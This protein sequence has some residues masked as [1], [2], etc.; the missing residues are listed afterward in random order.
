[1]AER[2][3]SERMVLI[4][5]TPGMLA[6]DLESTHA[7]AAATGTTL[8]PDWPPPFHTDE[9]VRR[10]QGT[11]ADPAGDGWWLHYFAAR[12]GDG[13]GLRL[14]GEG[15]FK[16]P[17]DARGMIEIGYALVPSAHGQGYATEASKAM[18]A[19]AWERGATVARAETLPDMDASI[20][21]MKRLGMTPAESAKDGVIAFEVRRPS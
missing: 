5:A 17:P 1:M 15:G 8:A 20:A 3:E 4:P 21:V 16:G 10:M 7:L 12:I 19:A 11:L 9:L 2:I 6:A 14:I 13:D 18:I